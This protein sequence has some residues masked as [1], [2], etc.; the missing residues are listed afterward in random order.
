[1][2]ALVH[3]AQ[4]CGTHLTH[5]LTLA[6]ALVSVLPLLPCWVVVLP[7]ACELAL[8]ST[9]GGWVWAAGEA[10]GQDPGL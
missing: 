1:M 3:M 6:S 7:P 4:A 10:L 8:S 2:C 9:N 5:L